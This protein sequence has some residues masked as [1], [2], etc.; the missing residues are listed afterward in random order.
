MTQCSGSDLPVRLSVVIPAFNAAGYIEEC[1]GS[2]IAQRDCPPFEVIVVDDGSV[3]ETA[4]I[5]R[6]RF[7]SVRLFR[8]SNGGPGSARNLGVAHAKGEIIIFIDSDDVM[9]PGRLSVQ[10]GFMLENSA[11][12]LTFGNQRFQLDP[13]YNSNRDRGI[14]DTDSFSVVQ[15]A[16]RRLLMEG[17]FISNTSCAVRRDAYLAVGGQPEDVFV[18]GD[19]AMHCA[20][21]RRWPVAASCKYFTWYRQGSGTNLMASE[22]TYRGPVWVLR[23]QLLTYGHTLEPREYAVAMRRWCHLANMLLRRIW[24]D[25][26]RGETLQELEKLEPLLPVGLA[27]KWRVISLLPSD[28]GRVARNAK[29]ALLGTAARKEAQA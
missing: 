1:L 16:F 15:E 3:D 22:H 9:L 10:G 12:G 23:E 27:W 2:V 8:K 26:G 28:V 25:F 20:I 4:Q 7:P 21:A 6:M 18:G 14:C 19:Y 17:N 11:V 13:E 29:R 24:V 5:V